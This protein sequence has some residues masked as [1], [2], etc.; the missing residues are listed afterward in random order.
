[1][2]VEKTH[3][4]NNDDYQSTKENIKSMSRDEFGDFKDKVKSFVQG[5][6]AMGCG[7]CSFDLQSLKW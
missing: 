3:I 1:M 5:G 4:G 2:P 6:V 7:R